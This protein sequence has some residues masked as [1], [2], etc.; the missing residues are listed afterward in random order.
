MLETGAYFGSQ[1]FG[2]FSPWLAL[3][4]LWQ[5]HMVDKATRFVAETLQ[6]ERG[7]DGSHTIPVNHSTRGPPSK[8]CFLKILQLPVMPL[9]LHQANLDYRSLL[10][11]VWGIQDP[12]HSDNESR[13]HYGRAGDEAHDKVLV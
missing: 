3:L 6:K 11:W 9:A 4:F 12:S 2:D 13:N 5:K 1:N 7:K 10:W 8:F